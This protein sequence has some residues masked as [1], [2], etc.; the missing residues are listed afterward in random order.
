MAVS[1]ALPEIVFKYFMKHGN[2]FFKKDLLKFGLSLDEKKILRKKQVKAEENEVKVID[3][4]DKLDKN[5]KK[6][7]NLLEDLEDASG[8]NLFS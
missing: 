1:P 7:D 3:F 6:M 8:Q 4:K 2:P 5:F